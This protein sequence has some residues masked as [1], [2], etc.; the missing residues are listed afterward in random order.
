M[1]AE[2]SS[3]YQGKIWGILY[4]NGKRTD[5]SPYRIMDAQKYGQYNYRVGDSYFVTDN[6]VEYNLFDFQRAY[7]AKIGNLKVPDQ[8]MEGHC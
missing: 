1:K 5:D 7:K 8:I 2:I 3:N 6:G 4:K